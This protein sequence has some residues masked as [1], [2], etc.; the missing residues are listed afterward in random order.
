MLL[1]ELNGVFV[2]PTESTK[3][4]YLTNA[5]ILNAAASGI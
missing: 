1:A 2:G 4:Q 3:M 5:S